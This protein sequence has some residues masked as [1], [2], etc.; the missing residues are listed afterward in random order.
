MI[1]L[2]FFLLPLVVW[3]MLGACSFLVIAKEETVTLRS[4]KECW[5]FIPLGPI[6]LILACWVVLEYM[7]EK[8]PNK[9]VVAKWG[10]TPPEDPP[11]SK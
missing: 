3:L 2:L 7:A 10:K 6:G 4:I 1:G 9:V 11:K 5:F 8:T